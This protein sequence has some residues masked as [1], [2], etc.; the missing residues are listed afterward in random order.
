MRDSDIDSLSADGAQDTA[1]VDPRAA[2][3]ADLGHDLWYLQDKANRRGVLL[4]TEDDMR[5]LKLLFDAIDGQAMAGG[6]GVIGVS[7][8]Y[9]KHEL[10]GRLAPIFAALSVPERDTEV[11][12]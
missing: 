10:R 4:V 9:W 8:A 5:V 1:R 7:A 6:T 12:E 2:L 11:T 3:A